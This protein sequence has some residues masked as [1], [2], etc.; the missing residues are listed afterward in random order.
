MMI[1]KF[2]M[3]LFLVSLAWLSGLSQSVQDSQKAITSCLL[4]KEVQEHMLVHMDKDTVLVNIYNYDFQNTYVDG[5]GENTHLF[6]IYSKESDFHNENLYLS[7]DELLDNKCLTENQLDCTI[8]Y[9]DKGKIEVAIL[10]RCNAT[11]V[12]TVYK[13][14][15][16]KL[17]FCSRRVVRY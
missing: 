13:Q 10:Y 7:S 4:S 9:L 17:K 12:R 15:T 3:T 1:S 2:Q 5:K 11:I 6:K 14:K 8:S 16:K